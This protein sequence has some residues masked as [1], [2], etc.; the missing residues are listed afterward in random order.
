MRGARGVS[1]V[2]MMFVLGLMGVIAG[3]SVPM[4][5]TTVGYFRLSGDARAVSNAVAVAK[6]RAAANFSR[7][8]LYVD[9][10]GRTFHVDSWTKTGTP[11]WTLTVGSW[12]LASRDSFGFA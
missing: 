4:I 11:D 8:R 9:L 6:M 2:E 7:T 5:S 1:L 12:M 10:T 3:I